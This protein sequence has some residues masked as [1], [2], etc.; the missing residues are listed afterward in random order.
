[1]KPPELET[2]YRDYIKLSRLLMRKRHYPQTPKV[3][4]EEAIALSLADQER[5][6]AMTKHLKQQG[7]K[8][9]LERVLKSYMT[10]GRDIAVLAELFQLSGAL[11]GLLMQQGET[12][13]VLPKLQASKFGQV[14]EHIE[15][16]QKPMINAL[17]VNCYL[18]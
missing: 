13:Q 17:L 3:E 15:S 10:S 2:C 9:V 11:D 1:M 6:E 12:L 4:C 5:E 14:T 18:L 7:F 8:S 16:L